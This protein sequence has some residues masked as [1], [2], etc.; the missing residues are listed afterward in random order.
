MYQGT[1]DPKGGIYTLW[2]LFGVSNQMLAGMALLLVTVVLFKMGRFK[3]AMVSALPAVLIL[4]IT[5]Y[6]GILKVVPKS[7]DSVLNNVSHVAQM[8]IIK[9]KIALTTD[10]KALKTLQKSFFNHAI[11]AI[12]CVF[13]ML[14]ALLVLIVS[15]RICSNAYFKNQIY[16]PLAETPYIK[17]A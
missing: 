5:F 14:V 15:V 11:D 13:F 7:N 3:G 6:S 12:L 8:Q 17:A 1:I 10:E 16:P 2:P 9:E 4:S